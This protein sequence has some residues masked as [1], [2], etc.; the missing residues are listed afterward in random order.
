MGDGYFLLR[1]GKSPR[2]G[3]SLLR[4]IEHKRYKDVI[5]VHCIAGERINIKEEESIP[6]D[7]SENSNSSK[8][9][10]VA[11]DFDVWTEENISMEKQLSLKEKRAH[12]LKIL[13]NISDLNGTV[14]RVGLPPINI[15]EFSF[16]ALRFVLSES[17]VASRQRW[18]FSCNGAEERM[19][20][21][22]D[23][24]ETILDRKN[25]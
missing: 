7:A 6:F 13:S 1:V 2:G 9:L 22:Q 24:F 17:D 8:P 11:T 10:A 20:Y 4:I 12:I 16:W 5:G 18:L 3:A 15:M 25:L 14:N 21:V 23:Y 19:Q